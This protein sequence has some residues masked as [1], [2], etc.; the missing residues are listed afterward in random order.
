MGTSKQ[1]P[2]PGFLKG[3]LSI[4]VGTSILLNNQN[5]NFHKRFRLLSSVKKPRFIFQNLVFL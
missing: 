1:V 3:I 2:H 5:T 4:G